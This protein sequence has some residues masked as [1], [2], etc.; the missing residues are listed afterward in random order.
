MIPLVPRALLLLAL[1]CALRAGQIEAPVSGQ[2][3]PGS[4]S[5]AIGSSL[6]APVPVQMTV[7]SLTGAA[8][9]SVLVGSGPGPGTA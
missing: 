7:P 2:V 5:G 6:G 3:A 4:Q 9:P 1:A 8:A